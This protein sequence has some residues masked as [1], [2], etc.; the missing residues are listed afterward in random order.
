MPPVPT[1][2]T[3]VLLFCLTAASAHSTRPAFT[4]LFAKAHSAE[5]VFANPAV[6]SMLAGT[7]MSGNQILV[8]D[9]SSFEVNENV[10]TVD[11]GNPRDSD[12]SLIPSFFYSRQYQQDW[13]FG[14]SLNVP[15]GF[16]ATNG[17]NWAG[18]YYSD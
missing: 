16:G 10:T 12:P 11:G 18:R 2:L 1:R 15:T 5:T 9:F 13:H 4:G 7:Q 17:S 14:A 6:M 8:V 3:L